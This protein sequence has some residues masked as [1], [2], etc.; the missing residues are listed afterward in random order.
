MGSTGTI[1]TATDQH[2]IYDVIGS[3]PGHYSVSADPEDD[4]DTFPR[5]NDERREGE[6]KSGDVWGRDVLV[7]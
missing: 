1:S 6:L 7:R 2:G 5:E 3:P 4:A